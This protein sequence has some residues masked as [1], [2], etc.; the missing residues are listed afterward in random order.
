MSP[1]QSASLAM[2]V[3][4]LAFLAATA[5]EFTGVGERGVAIPA[6]SFAGV[7][8]G[9][10]PASAPPPAAT[11][12]V[13]QRVSGL[14][15]PEENLTGLIRQYCVVC[16]NDQL[17]TGN[18]SL[19]HFDVGE[20]PKMAEH[21]EK[22]IGKLRA[23]MMP[24]P[25]MP[26]P[27]GDSLLALVETLER[28]VDEAAATD[29]NPGSRT[30]Q[31]LNQREYERAI[32]DLLG[33]EVYA[34]DWLPSDQ[35]SAN[36]DNIADVQALSA[37]LMDGYLNAA[38][39]I[40][41]MALG[42]ADVRA[43]DRVYQNSRFLS[44]HPWERVE[45]APYGTRG[46]ISVL[47]HFPMDG[48]YSFALEF[49]GGRGALLEMED[50]DISINGEQVALLAYGGGIDFQGRRT[51]PIRTE[52]VFI[53][54]GQH[55]VTAAFIR[56]IEGP[57]EDLIRPHEFSLTG[58]EVSYGTTS[59]PHV[60]EMTISG[61]FDPSGIS[62]TEVKRN[63]LTCRPAS[64][65]EARPCAEEILTGLA[66]RAYRRPLSQRDV[67][68][69]M[70]FYDRD[71]AEG[72]FELGLRSALEALLASPHFIFRLE[73]QP[74]DVR[75]GEA[76][77]IADLDLASRLSFF[78]WGT[79]PDEELKALAVEGRLS[80]PQVL[81]AQTLRM[82]RD[83]R[84]EALGSRFAGQWLRLQ[85][86]DKVRPDAFWFPE[87]SQQ[88]AEAMRMETELFFTSLIREDRSLFD[89][90]TADYSFINE[91]LARHYGIPG[92]VGDEFRRVQYPEGANRHGIFGHGSVLTL[93]SLGNRTSPVLRGKWVMEVL[94]DTPPP[95]PPPGV[96]DLEQTDG[97]QEGQVLTTRAR[98]EMHRASPVCSSC[99]VFMDPI[100]LALDNFDV[101]GR[102]RIREF[103]MPLD[104]RGELWNG[105][106]VS[107][108]GALA[109]ALVDFH[110][111]LVRTFTLNL[112]AYALG[113]RV[114]YYDQPTVRAIAR[115]AAEHDY[116]LSAFILGVV[117]SDAF[118]MKRPALMAQ[119][120]DDRN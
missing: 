50:I 66:T 17:E 95:P 103:G 14:E 106:P 100:G 58:V 107:T 115:Q 60:R 23:D 30:F 92:V 13:G 116:R 110:T 68:G 4:G 81:E 26:R 67:D 29:P 63:L 45:G 44:Q 43:S 12:P 90:Y 77:R 99:H 37:T 93:T 78:L 86:L 87:Y 108:P 35:I 84:A 47:H 61:P 105:A 48:H 85:D 83:P 11:T 75:S 25:G 53:P 102:W 21:A 91:R 72:G 51:I 113:R 117:Q 111:P 112:M 2:A 54:A 98:M 31:R 46:G 70:A 119:D 80:D 42:Q 9:S 74:E 65:A 97:V 8:A 118:Q 32:R 76:F 62:E 22:I 109:Q 57:Y 96:P 24:P 73:R 94:L 33:L 6:P 36:F 18:I 52:P 104:T 56:R 59:L 71:A 27:A 114:E 40:A 120:A 7:S 28:V 1:R 89:L 88:L 55:R 49:M 10:A 82:L 34:G 38:S 20:A 41:R 3:A 101:T 69:L 79:L 64:E 19:Q 39:E 5:V 15:I 16:H